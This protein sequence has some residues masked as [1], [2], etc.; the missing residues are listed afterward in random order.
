MT[1]AD[2]EHSLDSVR[3]HYAGLARDY[4][5]KANRACQSAYLR[6]IAPHTTNAG[7]VLELG[8]GCMSLLPAL[9]RT[10]RD[11]VACDLSAEMLLAGRA[12]HEEAG[13]IDPPPQVTGDAQRLPFADAAFDAAFC[14]NLLEH[15]P[16]PETVATEVARVLRPGGVLVAITPAGDCEGLLDFIERVHLKLPEGPHRFLRLQELAA[17]AADDFD[18]VESTRFLAFPAG[19]PAWVQAVDALCAPLGFGLFMY[20]VLRRKG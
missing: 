13:H 5:R 3:R 20:A 19:P 8:A 14:V 2:A 9:G 15:V 17:L 16:S 18:I 4:A 11:A 6:V 7:N 12:W 10:R 1:R